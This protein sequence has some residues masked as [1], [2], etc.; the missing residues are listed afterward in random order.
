M[1]IKNIEALQPEPEE[2][3]ENLEE[4]AEKSAAHEADE[5]PLEHMGDEMPDPWSDPKQTD[6]PNCD[7]VTAPVEAPKEVS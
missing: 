2:V 3:P 7:D 4:F 1:G 6:W 5:D